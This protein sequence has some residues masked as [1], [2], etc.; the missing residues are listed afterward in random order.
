MEL[1]NM[2]NNDSRHN[3]LRSTLDNIEKVLINAH[4]ERMGYSKKQV[5]AFGSLKNTISE[6]L[7]TDKKT[8]VA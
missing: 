7:S 5:D 4:N 6:R 3:N 8:K 1:T 2:N